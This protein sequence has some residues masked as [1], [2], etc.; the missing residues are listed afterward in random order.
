MADKH[1]NANKLTS[2]CCLTPT[3]KFFQLYHG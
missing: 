3:Q 1:Q 2:D